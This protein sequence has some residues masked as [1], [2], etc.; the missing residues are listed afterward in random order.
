M[1]CAVGGLSDTQ[2][3]CVLSEADK[4]RDRD[5]GENREERMAECEEWG[6]RTP[7]GLLDGWGNDLEGR[8]RRSPGGPGRKRGRRLLVCVQGACGDWGES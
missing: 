2:E 7:W 1:C 6:L 5:N 4:W 3:T 8:L